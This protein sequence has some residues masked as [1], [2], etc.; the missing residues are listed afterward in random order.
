MAR[1][2]TI[3]DEVRAVLEGL[4]GR[5]AAQRIEPDEL[6]RLRR[7]QADTEVLRVQRMQ[8]W[9]G[10]FNDLKITGPDGKRQLRSSPCWRARV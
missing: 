2:I 9:Q 1:T 10:G 6:A 3:S 5:L 4:I 8:E 7:A